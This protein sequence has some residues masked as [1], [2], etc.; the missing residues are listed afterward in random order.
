MKMTS[1]PHKWEEGK[2]LKSKISPKNAKDETAKIGPKIV[3]EPTDK[4]ILDTKK[5]KLTPKAKS[6]GTAI[7]LIIFC[8]FII[9]KKYSLVI[10]PTIHIMKKINNKK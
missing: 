2:T 6:P 3:K 5:T 1:R 10:V 7:F 9:V 4:S 8:K